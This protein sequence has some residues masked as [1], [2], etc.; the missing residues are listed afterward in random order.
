[1]EDLFRSLSG[2]FSSENAWPWLQAALLVIFGVTLA[3]LARRLI[4]RRRLHAQQRLLLGRAVSYAIVATAFVLALGRLGIDLSVL[5]GAAGV[6]TV[7][8]GFA[9][10]TS[11][12]NL[13]SGLFLLGE[14]PFVV[15]DVI[16]IGETTGEVVS[17][18]LMSVRL[19]TFDNLLVR[20]PNEAVLK[21]NVTN[22]TH[23][24]I[25]RLDIEI[26]VG[27]EQDM[28]KV[29]NVL[30][31]IADRNPICL[32]EP[33]PLVLVRAFGDNGVTVQFS[34]WSERVLFVDLRN[35]IHDAILKQFAA[36]DITIPFPQRVIHKST[37][38]PAPQPVQLG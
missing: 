21:A 1:M 29:R 22:L 27:Y 18:D 37:P 24:P 16:K 33:K 5:L 23:F 32:E 14:K 20:I 10:Q 3:R 26:S 38:S 15:S 19:R 30:A 36:N 34:V 13:I 7:A 9:A 2:S 17:V 4:H 6:L 31:A 12:S 11:M 28:A 8:L 35:T 25:R